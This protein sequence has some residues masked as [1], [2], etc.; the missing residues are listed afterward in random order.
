MKFAQLRG[1]IWYEFKMHWRRRALTVVMLAMLSMVLITLALSASQEF[2]NVMNSDS[3]SL[4]VSP[5]TLR[6]YMIVF[7]NWGYIAVVL[8]LILPIV[9]ADTIPLDRQL[10]AQELIESLPVTPEVYLTGKLIGAWA[11]MISAV[12]P[13]MVVS[14]AVFWGL[15]GAYDLGAYFAM[16]GVGALS[17]IILNGGMGVLLP[18][19]QPT[20]RRAIVLMLGLVFILPIVLGANL[21][22]PT[23]LID[24]LLLIRAPIITHYVSINR[25]Y[26]GLV[27][28]ISIGLIELVLVWVGVWRWWLWRESHL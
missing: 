24:Y 2:R 13:I 11:A 1:M 9:M 28:A 10:G 18:A 16:W 21:D 15:H 19:M 20:R 8:A 7:M 3:E 17:L 5:E 25:G 6:T 23:S 12:L 27:N 14:A 4:D 22:N 26:E